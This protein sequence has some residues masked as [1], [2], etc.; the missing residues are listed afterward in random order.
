MPKIFIT[1][2]IESFSYSGYPDDLKIAK[3]VCLSLIIVCGISCNVF[4]LI[5]IFR[6]ECEKSLK[7]KIVAIL[8]VINAS[9]SLGY[10]IELHA[11]I[12]NESTAGFCEAAAFIVCSLTYTSIGKII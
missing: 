11:A 12:I 3:I 4:G 2:I 9:Q 8:C 5:F 1:K 6:Q 7:D 10:A